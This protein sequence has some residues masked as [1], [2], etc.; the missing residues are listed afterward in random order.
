[1][2]KDIFFMEAALHEAEKAFAEGEVPVGAVI[3][4]D[5]EIIATFENPARGVC[6]GQSLVLYDGERLLGGGFIK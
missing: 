6:P 4:R 5:G 2:S 3:V 1:M